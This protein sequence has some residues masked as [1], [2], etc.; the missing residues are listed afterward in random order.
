MR[1]QIGISGDTQRNKCVQ[2]LRLLL[3]GQIFEYLIH[4]TSAAVPFA[5]LRIDEASSAEITPKPDT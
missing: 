3:G 5:D 2:N 4:A 1:E